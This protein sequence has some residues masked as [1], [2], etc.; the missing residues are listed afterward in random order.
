MPGHDHIEL[1]H[2]AVA[3]LRSRSTGRGL[4]AGM[5][6]CLRP[7][8]VADVVAVLSFQHRFAEAYKMLSQHPD[9]PMV[10][11]S[12]EAVCI[13]ECKVSRADFLSTFG[14]NPKHRVNR[15]EKQGTLHWVV[16]AK[17]VVREGDELGFWGLLEESGRGLREV[18]AP[19]RDFLTR[20]RINDVAYELLWHGQD[21]RPWK[22]RKRRGGGRL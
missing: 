7:G 16:A 4:R 1:Q 11:V 3:W 6:I 10:R 15:Y 18:R 12:D 17:G 9:K 22:A 14:P 5:E 8:Y 13:F 2:R 21:A 19:R 20:A